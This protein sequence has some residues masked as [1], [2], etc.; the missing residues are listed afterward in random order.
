MQFQHFPTLINALRMQSLRLLHLT[1]QSTSHIFLIYLRCLLQIFLL[2]LNHLITLPNNRLETMY[3]EHTLMQLDA[4][5][6]QYE[7]PNV[8]AI[9]HHLP[10][11]LNHNFLSL[12]WTLSFLHINY[13][14]Y[15]GVEW[16]IILTKLDR[17][18]QYLIKQLWFEIWVAGHYLIVET[19]WLLVLV[20][21]VE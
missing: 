4:P 13:T 16:L 20:F 19:E 17:T 15:A 12:Y 18:V 7:C 6:H 14:Q 3:V 9:L 5:Q 1:L 8:V 21:L 10:N 2:Q 11:Q